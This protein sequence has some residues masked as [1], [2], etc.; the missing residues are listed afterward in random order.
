MFEDVEAFK[1]IKSEYN[2]YWVKERKHYIE[3]EASLL[4]LTLSIDD[5]YEYKNK[6]EKEGILKPILVWLYWKYREIFDKKMREW[7]NLGEDHNNQTKNFIRIYLERD[8]EDEGVILTKDGTHI[9]PVCFAIRQS[10]N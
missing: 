5:R 6:F 2:K 3:N 9:Y 1:K 7:F 8:D 4:D 10:R